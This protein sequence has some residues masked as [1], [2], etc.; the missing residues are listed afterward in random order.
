MPP[1]RRARSRWRREGVFASGSLESWDLVLL[2][3]GR[4]IA[5]GRQIGRLPGA[6][7]AEEC[8]RVLDSVTVQVEHRP[9]ARVLVHSSTVRD[10]ELVPRKFALGGLLFEVGLEV[11][12]RIVDR[13]LDVLE[14]EL[15]LAADVDPHGLPV[16]DHLARLITRNAAGGFVWG[17]RGAG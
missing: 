10:Q 3:D 1:A 17:A 11:R 14:L 13:A 7:A 5:F 15:V 2:R 12:E 16:L 8:C 6:P 4:R 9:G